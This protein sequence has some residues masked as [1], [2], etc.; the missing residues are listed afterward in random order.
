[1][2]CPTTKEAA[3]EHSQTTAAAISSGVPMRPTGS[4]AITLLGGTTGQGCAVHRAAAPRQ[5]GTA[6]GGLLGDPPAGRTGGDVATR[7]PMISRIRTTPL[8]SVGTVPPGVGSLLGT[9][10]GAEDAADRAGI[11]R[12]GVLGGAAG[13]QP[14]QQP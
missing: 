8:V 11:I 12:S 9:A 5:P 7:S 4:W 2:A 13:K 14:G 3:S 6:P 10:A 1:M